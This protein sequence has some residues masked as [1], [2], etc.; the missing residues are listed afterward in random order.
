[1]PVARANSRN[2]INGIARTLLVV[3]RERKESRRTTRRN[4]M[5][6]G[7]EDRAESLLINSSTKHG[8][9]ITSARAR[10]YNN[11][12]GPIT[13]YRATLFSG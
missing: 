9:A 13:F 12:T 7:E 10:G 3:R 2:E 11:A 4:E 8:S 6:R 1:M 5:D